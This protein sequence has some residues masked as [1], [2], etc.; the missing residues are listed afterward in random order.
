MSI[1][2]E[3]TSGTTVLVTTCTEGPLH[4]AK[5]QYQDLLENRKTAEEFSDVDILKTITDRVTKQRDTAKAASR[6]AALWIQYME[7]IDL[8]RAF[9]R[10]EQTA[11]WELHLQVVAQ[12]LPYFAASGH[13]LYAKCA[14][15]SV[16]S[17]ISL[18][19]DRPEVYQQF[20]SGYHVARRSDRFWARLSSDLE[21]EQVLMRSLKISGGLTQGSGM[22]EQERLIWLLSIPACAKTSAAMQELTGVKYNSSEQNKDITIARQKRDMNDTITVLKSLA[23]G[24]NPFAQEPTLKNITTG[25]NADDSV[26]VGKALAKG[27]RYCHP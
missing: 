14:Y 15:L 19:K 3:S 1:A 9:I 26:D 23:D 24:K 11:N 7:M 8:L 16:R 21:I 2:V 12:M 22:T 27:E 6:T 17:M 25:V 13:N 10:A 18:K 5:R 20:A 4:E